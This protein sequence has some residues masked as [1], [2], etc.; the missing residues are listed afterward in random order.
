VCG[1]NLN[2]ILGKAWAP[3]A[4]ISARSRV[5]ALR[6]TPCRFHRSTGGSRHA[7]RPSASLHDGVDVGSLGPVDDGRRTC[8]R[9][10]R[11]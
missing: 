11:L 4:Q 2:R 7:G 3:P 6:R 8:R 5:P 1:T 9:A 10:A